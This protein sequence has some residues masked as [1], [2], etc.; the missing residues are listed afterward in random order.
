MCVSLIDTCGA[1]VTAPA[2]LCLRI[3]LGY[4]FALARHAAG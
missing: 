3:T 2:H 1:I 4:Q